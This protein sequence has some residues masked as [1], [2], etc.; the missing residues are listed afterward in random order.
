MKRE[1]MVQKLDIEI[2]RLETMLV[3]LGESSSPSME[4]YLW[5]RIAGLK[6]VK[7]NL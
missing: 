4:D 2:T 5:G 1:E 3:F 7:E 6:W